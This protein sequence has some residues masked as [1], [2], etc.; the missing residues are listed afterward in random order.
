MKF[1][2]PDVTQ[3]PNLKGARVIVRASFDVPLENGEVR[4]QFRLLRSLP[5]L[6]YLTR[7][8]AKVVIISHIGRDPEL[9]LRPVYEVLKEHVPLL[10]CDQLTGTKTHTMV[11]RLGEGE[12]VLLENLRGDE[13]EKQNDEAFAKELSQYGGVF[14]NDAFAVSHRAHAS[15]VGIPKFL[16]SYIGHT[17]KDEYEN[18]EKAEK[19]AS[20]SLFILGGAKFETKRPLIAKYIKH[21]DTVF[22]GGAI[23]NDFFKAQ[24]HDV[25]RSLVSSEDAGVAELLQHPHV[26][27]PVDVVVATADGERRVCTLND[28]HKNESILDAGPETS[29]LLEERIGNVAFILWNGPLGDYEH[30]FTDATRACAKAIGSSDAFSVIGGGDTIAA[31]ESLGLNDK[32]SFLS[33]AGGAMLAF[34]EHSTLPGIEAILESRTRLHE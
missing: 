2:L 3:I 7:A 1:E 21:Y 32:F 22:V 18:L 23:A 33:T 27:L 5:T 13:R 17:F 10:W 31:I 8:G 30:T 4:N 29:R 26:M 28:V 14:V 16:P 6:L 9:S 20:P 24:G 12:A 11:E 34:L 19:P 15:I 25:G